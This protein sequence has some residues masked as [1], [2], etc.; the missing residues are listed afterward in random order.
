MAHD[1]PAE[2]REFLR[3]LIANIR[4]NYGSAMALAGMDA[5]LIFSIHEVAMEATLDWLVIESD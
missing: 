3:N 1:G 4:M 5:D 2:V